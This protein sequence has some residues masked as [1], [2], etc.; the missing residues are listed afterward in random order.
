MW[1]HG[2]EAL[3]KALAANKLFRAMAKE[4]KEDD[5]EVEISAELRSY[6]VEFET[7]SLEL[8]DYSYRSVLVEFS[9]LFLNQNNQ[10][11]D[12]VH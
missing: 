5:L 2:E 4:A 11:Y 8:L 7:Y 9:N 10:L 12:N 3:P 6:A 1:H